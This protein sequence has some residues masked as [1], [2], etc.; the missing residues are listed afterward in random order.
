MFFCLP[1]YLVVY[2][3]Q[4]AWLEADLKKANEDRALRPWIF[5]QGHHPMYQGSSINKEFQAA[6]EELFFTYGVDIY[7]CGHEHFY[8][9]SY[10]VYNSQVQTSYDYPTD[11]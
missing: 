5:V 9:R 10:P 11:R 2:S 3:F 4:L 8:E 6:A 1:F 7:F